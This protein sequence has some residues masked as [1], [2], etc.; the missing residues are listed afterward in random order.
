MSKILKKLLEVEIKSVDEKERTLTAVASTEKPDRYGDIIRQD[1]WD[2]KNFKKNP[3][4]P[5]GHDYHGF[6]VAKII[7]IWVEDK[8]LM[9]TAKFAGLEQLHEKAETVFRLFKDGFLRAFSVGFKPI[10]KDFNEKTNGFV[11]KKCELLEVSAVTV[12]ANPQAL[13]KAVE[14]G[15]AESEDEL[16]DFFEVRNL[17]DEDEDEGEGEGDEEKKKNKEA[18]KIVHTR[19]KLLLESVEEKHAALVGKEK[20]IKSFRKYFTEIQKLLKIEDEEDEQKMIE[21]TG[22]KAVAILAQRVPAKKAEPKPAPAKQGQTT[23]EKKAEPLLTS[24][25]AEAIGKK[26]AEQIS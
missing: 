20:L 26:I 1:G 19:V 25:F 18:E 6:P 22:L 9:F 7:K 2:F 23:P 13:A 5:W 11:F 14:M 12:P 8:K 10:E 15:I 16:K 17:E 3:V 21:N 24:D 4:V